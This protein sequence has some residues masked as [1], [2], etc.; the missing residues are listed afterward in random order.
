MFS[1]RGKEI[2]ISE[3]KLAEY[4]R[5]KGRELRQADADLY[6]YN[7]Y[8]HISKNC[9]IL[10]EKLDT[11]DLKRAIAHGIEMEIKIWQ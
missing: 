11:E 10:A 5:H 4:K 2:D 8:A 1:Y 7:K 6:V 9:Q 3:E